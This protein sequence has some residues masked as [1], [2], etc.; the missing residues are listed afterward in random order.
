MEL[1]NPLSVAIADARYARIYQDVACLS[2]DSVGDPMCI[3]GER[4]NGKW[5]VE[6]ADPTNEAKMPAIGIL[7]SKSTPTVG[8]VQLFGPVMNIF[9]GLD[10]S[11]LSYMVGTSGIQPTPPLPGPGGYV[12]VQHIG[13]PVAS[14]ILLLLGDLWMMKRR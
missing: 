8:V 14:D 13:K 2:S 3:R 4:V 6:R 12:W 9:T 1:R 5:R 7:V 10:L 11:A